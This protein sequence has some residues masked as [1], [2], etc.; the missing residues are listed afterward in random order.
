MP[1]LSS[2]SLPIILLVSIL[3]FE[4]VASAAGSNDS[5]VTVSDSSRD[6]SP[7]HISD[8][9][10]VNRYSLYHNEIVKSFWPVLDIR[11]SYPFLL[12][13]ETGLI[14]NLTASKETETYD[15]VNGPVVFAE[16]SYPGIIAGFGANFGKVSVERMVFV[17]PE[18]CYS[19]V[20]TNRLGLTNRSQYFGAGITGS[21]RLVK[22]S[23]RILRQLRNPKGYLP[24]F[25]IGFGI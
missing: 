20:W 5:S 14:L 1:R 16:L 15:P 25:G 3:P 13:L 10:K 23:F 18:M 22:C 24:Y 9:K 21:F 2:I 12:S 17:R 19:R 8:S 6:H 7:A 4:G 11:A